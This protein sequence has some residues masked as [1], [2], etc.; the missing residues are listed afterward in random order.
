MSA[1]VDRTASVSASVLAGKI[2]NQL[3]EGPYSIGEQC[4]P[5]VLIGSLLHSYIEVKNAFTSVSVQ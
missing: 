1:V 4:D 2:A 3:Y 5:L